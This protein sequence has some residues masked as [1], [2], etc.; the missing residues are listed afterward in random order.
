MDKQSKLQEGSLD[1]TDKQISLKII[2]NTPFAIVTEKGQNF[3]VIGKHRI[4]ESYEKIEELEE[5]LKKI[6]WDKIVQVIWAVVKQFNL[7]E[8]ENE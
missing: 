7:K 1:T 4:T 8:K 5:E 3:G 6:D 2:E